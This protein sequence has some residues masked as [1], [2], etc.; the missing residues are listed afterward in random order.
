MNNFYAQID[1]NGI[2]YSVAQ[3][4]GAVDVPDLIPLADF[5][6]SYLGKQWDALNKT[7]IVPFVP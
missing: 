5:S 6:E 3:L 4:A 7:W 2:C 1:A